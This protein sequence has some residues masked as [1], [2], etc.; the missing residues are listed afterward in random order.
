MPNPSPTPPLRPP[1]GANLSKALADHFETL[2]LSGHIAPGEKLPS[3]LEVMKTHHLSRSVIREALSQLQA[4]GRVTTRHGIGTFASP[5]P[6]PTDTHLPLAQNLADILSVM[7][8]RIS[9][10]AD[11]AAFA[12]LR[13]SPAQLETLRTLLDRLSEGTPL[14][15]PRQDLDQQ[16]HLTISAATGNRYL[17]EIM[18]RFY[19]CLIPRM[20]LQSNYLE[21]GRSALFLQ[22]RDAE[23]E[24][25]F[26]AI[27][28][29]DAVAASAAMRLHLSN[30]R[31]RLSEICE[32]SPPTP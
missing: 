23:H 18:Q 26:L 27:A 7:E 24:Q 14:G 22:R 28:R 11:A 17:I 31:E 2:I 10:E 20:Q 19:G 4:R 6:S 12:A 8:V 9:L 3:E 25:L 13:R 30:S 5:Q 16:L 1:K 29:Q 32:T 21:S 15:E